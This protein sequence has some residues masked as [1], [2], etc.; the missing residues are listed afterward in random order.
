MAS[1]AVV[2]SSSGSGSRRSSRLTEKRSSPRP[3]T[4]QHL[5]V[6]K[7][8]DGGQQLAN[9]S[10][11]NHSQDV[12]AAATQPTNHSATRDQSS[13]LLN[14]SHADHARGDSA[15]RT[16][17]V[18]HS[19]AA[20]P[21]HPG[22]S[23]GI[24]G[25]A[26]PPYLMIGTDV[27]AKYKGAFCEAKIKKVQTH[28][29][30]RVTFKGG[31][32]GIVVPHDCIRG[33]L[34]VGATVEAKLPDA[35]GANAEYREATITKITDASQY[36][37]VFDDGDETTL[38]RTA[39]CLKSG[40]H[41]AESESL[42]HLP[43]TNPEHFAN[44]VNSGRRGGRRTGRVRRRAA[45][46]AS[47]ANYA[48][49]VS[50]ADDNESA[51]GDTMGSVDDED[52]SASNLTQPSTGEFRSCPLRDN[53]T[54]LRC[55]EQQTGNSRDP[56]VGRVIIAEFDKR[57]SKAK[58]TWFPGL[59]VLREAHD[60]PVGPDEYM[61][62]SFKDSR[63]FVVAKKDTREYSRSMH[64]QLYNE[65]TAPALKAA[66]EKASAYLDRGEVPSNW[67][68]ETLIGQD[69]ART[70][71]EAGQDGAMASSELDSAA[72]DDFEEE[73]DT[74]NEERD[75]FVAQL[76]KFMDERAT[77]LNRVN[78]FSKMRAIV[79][80]F[81]RYLTTRFLVNRYRPL[82]LKTLIFIAFIAW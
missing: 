15:N 13:P 26:E 69:T 64:S 79:L 29:K 40:K 52:D 50:D 31:G 80:L 8:N 57:G 4:S 59:V 38:K 44:T 51:E 73:D 33:T 71:A 61:V 7:P 36:T 72:D 49:N 77:P 24:G 66:V 81:R 42:D 60:K 48:A 54:V 41:Y 82:V 78:C 58:D 37:V 46:N 75:R 56:D 63:Y 67:D 16:E 1:P 76:Y 68:L 23:Y 65:A 53:N 21:G 39:L 2:A 35:K 55:V 34:R 32:T 27:S 14:T 17:L 19:Q 6:S 30:C 47:D 45:A 9:S 20:S 5:V 3:A 10:S 25:D 18:V 22:G 70:D 12:A 74:N 28:V 11:V 62:K 43:L